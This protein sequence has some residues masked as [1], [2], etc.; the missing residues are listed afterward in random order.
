MKVSLGLLAESGGQG[1]EA[2]SH[3]HRIAELEREVKRLRQVSR[4]AGQ[5]EGHGAS[6]LWCWS[7]V[8]VVL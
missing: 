8:Q 7:A 3:L 6:G 1:D 5:E 2:V 4:C